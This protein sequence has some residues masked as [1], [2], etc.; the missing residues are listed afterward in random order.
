MNVKMKNTFKNILIL[1][2][3]VFGLA[4]CQ[5][6]VADVQGV[7]G[8]FAYLVDGTQAEYMAP[9]CEI[10]HTPIGELGEIK[11][12]VVVALTK[13]QKTDVEVVLALDNT[14]LS[15]GYSVF[16]DDVVKFDEKVIIPAGEKSVTFDMT[17]EN[18]D[19]AKL[20]DLKYQAILR[21]ASASGVKISSNS[22][23]AYL[24]VVTETIDPA[25][26]V[27]N[28]ANSTSTFEI[29]Q[30]HGED[31]SIETVAANITK[32]ITIKGTE[33]A[34]LPFEITLA[35]APELIAAYNEANGTSYVAVPEEVTVNITSPVEMVKDATTVSATVSVSEADQAKLL[36]SNGYLIPVKVTNVGDATLSPDCGVSYIAI[37]V[38]NIEG[39]ANYF[40]ALY[41]GDYR[42]STWYMFQK[43]IDLSAGYTIIFHM[44]IDEFDAD[45]KMRIGD[46]ADANEKWINMLRIGEKSGERSLEWFAGPDGARV[47]LY[48][49]VLEA[50]KWYQIALRFDNNS[51]QLYCEKTKVAEYKLSDEEKERMKSCV[52]YPAKFQALEFNSSWGA[53]YRNGSAFQGRLWY[54]SVWNKAISSSYITRYAY[55]TMNQSFI[56][57]ASYYGLC[58]FWPMDDAAGHILVEKSGRYENI[59]FTKTTRCDDESSMTSADVSAYVGWKNDSFNS[60]D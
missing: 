1:A 15:D 21:I 48:T 51:Y 25:N 27:I 57:N 22:N 16:P 53:N 36:D 45:N 7:V 17:V 26:N 9:T 43:P 47:K 12:D 40:S 2:A 60:F 39:S 31:G 29:K 44:F 24:M 19:F 10:F 30:Y 41:L 55:R 14:N 59:D 13:V 35:H 42:M 52:G 20:V 5:E 28:V 56:T 50:Q 23:A 32:N 58:A 33:P 54:V 11:T 8:D 3:A 18:K 37:N 6:E 34:F 4:A 38:K 49:P 46:F